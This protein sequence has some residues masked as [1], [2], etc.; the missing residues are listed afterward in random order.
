M[1]G[2]QLKS[3]KNALKER[4]LTGQTNVKGSNK[5]K[6]KAR[7]YDR[8]EKAKTIAKI[9]EQ[10]NPFDVKVNRNKRSADGNKSLQAV[11]KPGISKQIGE[12]Q[13]KQIYE[14]RNSKKNRLGGVFDRRFGENHKGL[15]EEEKMLE[16]FTRE[17]QSQASF[18][19]KV[20]IQPR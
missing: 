12:E 15:T 8:E 18:I 14:A 17:R 1:A 4:G 6:R 13:R 11:G 5:L 9:R 7:E 19:E 20:I 2:S 3:L 10:F 16:R